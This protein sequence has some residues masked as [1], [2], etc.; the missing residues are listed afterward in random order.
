M[1]NP[2]WRNVWKSRLTQ[3]ADSQI[4]FAKNSYYRAKRAGLSKVIAKLSFFLFLF[5]IGS[6]FLAVVGLAVVARD[7]PRPDRIV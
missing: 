3:L 1:R 7:L 5:V 2:D 6:S 4:S